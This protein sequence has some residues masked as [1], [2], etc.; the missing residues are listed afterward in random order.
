MAVVAG[1]IALFVVGAMVVVR[2]LVRIDLSD[3]G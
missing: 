3:D 1:V 2:E